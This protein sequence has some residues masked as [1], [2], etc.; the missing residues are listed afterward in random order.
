[1]LPR[2]SCRA[3]LLFDDYSNNLIHELS[4]LNRVFKLQAFPAYDAYHAR[5]HPFLYH[6]IF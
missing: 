5:E 4:F 3:C 6:V 2:A 1:M